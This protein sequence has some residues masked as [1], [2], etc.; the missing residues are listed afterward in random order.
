MVI[1][2]SKDRLKEVLN[3]TSG[4]TNATVDN[5]IKSLLTRLG[6]KVQDAGIWKGQ[7]GLPRYNFCIKPHGAN[8]LF[9]SKELIERYEKSVR[10]IDGNGFNLGNYFSKLKDLGYDS[11]IESELKLFDEL[12]STI[13][14]EQAEKMGISANS[15]NW[16][17][18][19]QW[20]NLWRSLNIRDKTDNK[21]KS[22]ICTG[23]KT[24]RN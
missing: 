17:V 20:S 23:N 19:S 3:K 7:K 22:K 24:K 1:T 16:R 10:L 5:K 14:N 6:N 13:S 21:T 4:I 15:R 18:E 2:V 11:C 9:S 12:G 8:Y